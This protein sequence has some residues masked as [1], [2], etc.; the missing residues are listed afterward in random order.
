MLILKI[1]FRNIFRNTRRSLTTLSTIAIGAAAV[2]V[3]GAYVTYIAYGVATNAV[4]R[5][6]HFQVFRNGYF[7]F[8]AAA[9]GA[10]GI[11]DYANI[12]KLI[13][14]DRS[15]TSGRRRQTDQV[16]FRNR[17]QLREQHLEDL[18]RSRF[19]SFGAR[20]H[21]AMERIRHRLAGPPALQ[22]QR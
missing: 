9:P 21:E 15:D 18:L 3:F 22:S 1:A 4:Q 16:A 2:L 12:L 8:A 5:T 10:W 11:D 17:R 13:K 7:N 20:P 14:S 6:G 19:R